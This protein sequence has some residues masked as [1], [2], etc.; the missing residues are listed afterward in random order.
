M[1]LKL[2]IAISVFLLF[3]VPGILNAGP[4]GTKMGD[5]KETYLDLQEV[6]QN[7]PGFEMYYTTK[8]P[9]RHSLFQAYILKFGN[10]GLVSVS[11]FSK[12]FDNDR[13]GRGALRAYDNIKKQL[14]E[15]Y[16]VSK[17]FEFLNQNGLW[18][19]EDEFA[20]SLVH[21]E[22]QHGCE[23]TKNLPDDLK[24]IRLMLIGE[25]SDSIKIGLLY[26]YTN[27]DSANEINEKIEKDS[28]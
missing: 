11:G 4:F 6:N 23:W 2:T 18:K 8:V 19:D 9:K 28:L 14:T 5:A 10:T 7:E 27:I 26:E 25:S 1:N 16:G 3:L 21:N 13:Y 15:K 20:M 24:L 17:N 12:S 22:R